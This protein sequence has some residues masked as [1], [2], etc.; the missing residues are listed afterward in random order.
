MYTIYCRILTTPHSESLIRL[1]IVV[2]LWEHG[3]QIDI[4]FVWRDPTMTHS[5]WNFLCRIPFTML[6]L[7]KA[8]KMVWDLPEV[9]RVSYVFLLVML[10]WMVL[11]SFGVSG[12]IA[13]NIVDSGSWWLLVVRWQVFV[14]SAIAY[15]VL[16]LY[17]F[18]NLDDDIFL[19]PSVP[20][21]FLS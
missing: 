4:I 18:K 14:L 19:L 7:Q 20:A 8:V 2:T 12:V 16:L 3:A 1:L 5:L 17:M 11:W 10:C 21:D 9:M 13:L 15:I 6:V